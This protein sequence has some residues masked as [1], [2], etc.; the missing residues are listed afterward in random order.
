[1][2][3]VRVSQLLCVKGF[4]CVCVKKGVC[5]C[6]VCKSFCLSL[7]EFVCKSVSV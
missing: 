3:G 7:N 2:N 4:L 1:V 6:A 5:V